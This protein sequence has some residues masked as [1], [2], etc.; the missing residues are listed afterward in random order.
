MDV[1]STKNLFFLQAQ[2]ENVGLCPPFYKLVG[3]VVLIPKENYKTFDM[4]PEQTVLELGR[5]P[6]PIFP[7]LNSLMRLERSYKSINNRF[8]AASTNVNQQGS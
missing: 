3:N 1:E 2:L 5:I 7:P 6:C 8:P 4:T